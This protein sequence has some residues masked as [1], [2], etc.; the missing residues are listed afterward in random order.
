MNHRADLVDLTLHIHHLTDAAVR[1]S[2]DGLDKN[3][4]WLPLSQV[5]IE[6]LDQHHLE[7]V[8]SVPLWLAETK[9]LV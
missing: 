1:V 2:D 8:V 7:A 6:Y 9:G 4:V 5:E 3:G